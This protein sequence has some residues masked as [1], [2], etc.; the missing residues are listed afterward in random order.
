MGK[1]KVYYMLGSILAMS[2]LC[3]GCQKNPKE[4]YVVR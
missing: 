4:D 1:K 2:M 3:Q